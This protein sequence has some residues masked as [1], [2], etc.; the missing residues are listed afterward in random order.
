MMNT[1]LNSK[2]K[3]LVLAILLCVFS[4]IKGQ[5]LYALKIDRNIRFEA[6]EITARYQPH[7]VMGADQ[8]LQ[9]QSTVARYLVKKR[10]VQQ[11]RH[12]P[13]KAR[14]DLLKRIST[15]ETSEMADVL[16]SYRWQVYMQIKP[17]IQPIP[18]PSLK[19]DLIVQS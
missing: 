14:Y 13:P 12:L 15:R 5:T 16:E 8:A 18:E 7:L 1:Y 19:E 10:A 3:Y 17:V 6:R 9:F 2:L 4:S 11:N